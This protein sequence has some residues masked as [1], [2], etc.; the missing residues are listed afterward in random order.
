MPPADISIHDI[1][2]EMIDSDG[3][4]GYSMDVDG[5]DMPVAVDFW[6]H[7]SDRNTSLILGH[8]SY[9]GLW[10]FMLLVL[11]AEPGTYDVLVRSDSLLGKA[12]TSKP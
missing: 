1:P 12:W 2:T 5:Q 11:R 9:S 10:T 6:G 7:I 8:N 3:G 4:L